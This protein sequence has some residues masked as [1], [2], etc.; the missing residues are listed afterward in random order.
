MNQTFQSIRVGI[1]FILGLALI[2][3]VYTVIGE[4]QFRRAEGYLL[5]AEFDDIRTLTT[6]ADVRM[7]GV[8]IGEVAATGLSNGRGQ[9]TLR[10]DPAVRI[11]A[12]SVARIQMA[13][14]LGQ[15]YV[16]VEYGS[17][18]ET[19]AGGHAIR[20]EAGPDF[21]QILGELQRLGERINRIADSFGGLGDS[22]LGELFGNLNRLVTDNR[23]RFDSVMTNLDELTTKLNQGQGT[24]GRLINEDGLYTEVMAVV[25]DFRSASEDLKGALSGVRDLIAKV[26]AGEG[27]LGR[28]LV[29]DTIAGDLQ[30]AMANLREFSDKLNSGQGTLG[31]L[32]TDDALYRDLKGLLDRAGQALDSVGD[33]GPISALGAVS[34][35]LF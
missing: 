2:Y 10:I 22:G 32:V 29:D 18:A 5:T 30:A 20:T 28:L 21:N 35:A 19:L 13:S 23:G 3:A 24:L 9:V 7:A 8:R 12:D 17:A 31:L 6:G 27:T 14:L 4:R 26:E 1:F 34:G 33:A 16:A 25:T 11:P 15:N